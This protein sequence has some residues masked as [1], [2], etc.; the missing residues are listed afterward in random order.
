M[1]NQK[2]QFSLALVTGATSGIGY[3]LCHLLAKQGIH[4]IIVGRNASQLSLLEE[5]LQS[6]VNVTTLVAD[7]AKE[8]DRRNVVMLIKQYAPDLVINNAGFGLYGE[9]ISHPTDAQLEILDVNGKALLELTLEAA[10]KLVS[11]GKQGVIL[12]VASAAAYLVAPQMA[13]YAAAKS[14]VKQA[15]QALDFELQPKGVRVLVACPGMV[16][17]AFATRAAGKPIKIPYLTMTPEYA[18]EQIWWQI[19]K[20]KQC[21]L[22]GWRTRWGVYLSKLFPKRWIAK[23]MQKSIQERIKD[24]G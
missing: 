11:Q 14:F 3:A 17:T 12:N 8:N 21:H 22:F 23:I 20:G 18:A 10:K 15:S 19:Q 16:D 6:K 1:K 9:A 4:L 24:E 7:L 13:V 2:N 5:Q